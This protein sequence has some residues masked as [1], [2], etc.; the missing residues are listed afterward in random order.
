MNT[1]DFISSNIRT[2]LFN[3]VGTRH[4]HVDC[5]DHSRIADIARYIHREHGFPSRTNRVVSL[6]SGPQRLLIPDAYA[7]HHPVHDDAPEDD[8]F[9]STSLDPYSHDETERLLND[10]FS[11]FS[12]ITVEL[13][14]V[15]LVVRW[16]GILERD[17]KKLD[18][19][20]LELTGARS[21][22]PKHLTFEYHHSINIPK[23]DT[24]PDVTALIAALQEASVIVGSVY[25]FDSTDYLA[26]RTN[27]FIAP[28][29][30]DGQAIVE[31]AS[32]FQAVVRRLG[33]SLPT[34]TALERVVNIWG[35]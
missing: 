15:V 24:Q 30:D 2:G 32:R 25:V 6:H 21:L 33:Y 29:T 20:S 10:L 28:P 27:A 3:R 18:V 12:P 8:S 31:E 13:E 26:Y 11:R 34:R 7:E 5:H 4:F 14:E 23:E 19:N 9:T 17:F 22:T 35:T 1:D 16:D